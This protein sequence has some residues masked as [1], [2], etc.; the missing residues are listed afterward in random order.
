[1]IEY[2]RLQDI[3]I[4]ADVEI[5]FA[6]GFTCLTGET[7]AGK[8]MILSA[9]SLLLGGRPPAGLATSPVS[10]VE[11]G[12]RLD[13]GHPGAEAATE[14]GARL[15]DGL[16]IVTRSV[17]VGGRG[18]CSIG[19]TGVPAASLVDFAGD[20]VV[21]HGQAEQLTLRRPNAQQ[22]MLDRFGGEAINAALSRYRDAYSQVARLDARLAELEASRDQ[23]EAQI[24]SLRE[25]LDLICAAD[26][27]PGEDA[28]L[29][30][31][32]QRL[33]RVDD[34]RVAVQTALAAVA[35]EDEA[36]ARSR[37]GSA[38]RALQ[39]AASTDPGLEP[40]AH[41]MADGLALIEDATA[42]A[43]R[44]LEDL[45]SD[46]ARLDA[47]QT[48]LAALNE[49]KRR[50]GPDI[51]GVLSWAKQASADLLE[52][53]EGLDVDAVRERRAEARTRLAAA[54]ADL[55]AERSRHG[56]LLADALTHELQALAM[57]RARAAIEVTPLSPKPNQEPI[58]IDG[59]DCGFGPGGTDTV[60]FLL[61][62]HP[63]SDLRPIGQSASGGELSRIMLALQV[64]LA[65][66]A[67]AT[68]YVFDEVDA[69]IGG[70]AAI[71]VGRR[72]ARA[73]RNSQVVVITH[74]AQVAAWAD[75][76]LV[77]QKRTAGG[78]TVAGVSR[79]R[80][81]DRVREI[82][83]MLSGQPDSRHALAHAREL[84]EV[85]QRDA[86]LA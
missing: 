15:D 64:A 43:R 34:L 14:L 49:L 36:D 80:G 46:P 60:R 5:D 72:L 7:G 10:R 50:F 61:A 57:P 83:R 35:D 84:L 20:L 8:T 18:R 65:D 11:G 1:M 9:L 48:R 55:R 51:E 41:A 39:G 21:V 85:A 54:G 33:A 71:E 28:A 68:T 70:Q 58:R 47:C 22:E 2:I 82:A 13:P 30:A 27:M 75:D 52:L 25:G 67:P 16:L 40:V 62:P 4:V 63:G 3:G 29:A 86:L 56:R 44:Y 74:L 26:P 37:L 79:V 31:D 73:A 78:A 42:S 45:E 77:V 23:V 81:E 66:D 19:G 12:W 24:A 76:H 53:D 69:G 38:V 6:G 17:P 59:T 32:I